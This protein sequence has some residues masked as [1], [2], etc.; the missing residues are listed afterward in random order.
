M[1]NLE[2]DLL[3]SATAYSTQ[4]LGFEATRDLLAQ[5]LQVREV[6]ATVS[7]NA[8]S[9]KICSSPGL[10]DIYVPEDVA[11]SMQPEGASWLLT[12]ISSQQRRTQWRAL[13]ASA[14]VEGWC[15]QRPNHRRRGGKG[16]ERWRSR[17]SER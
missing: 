1:A 5:K 7:Q 3:Q 11:R 8:A 4:Q 14:N 12:V 16:R 9:H 6:V 2:S 17:V 15:T 13:H 10:G